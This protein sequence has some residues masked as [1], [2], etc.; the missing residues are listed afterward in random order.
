MSLSASLVLHTTSRVFE[1]RIHAG[2]VLERLP[3]LRGIRSGMMEDAVLILSEKIAGKDEVEDRLL[4]DL[5][6]AFKRVNGYSDLEISQ[7]RSALENVLLPETILTHKERLERAGFSRV[8]L[9]FQCFNFVS[10]IARP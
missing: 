7:K 2:L 10:F 8:D 5:H 1:S 4:V 3:L 6:H 9:W